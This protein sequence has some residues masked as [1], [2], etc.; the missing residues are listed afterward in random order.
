MTLS[1]DEKVKHYIELWKQTVSVQQHFNDIEW[2]IRGLALT[3]ATF[4]IG[5][6]AV[7]TKEGQ[8]PVA[9]LVL[10]IGL[11]L[12]YAFYFVDRYWYHP[13][14][15]ASV[16]QG[17]KIED[18]LVSHGLLNADLAK[19]IS[20]GSPIDRPRLIK[21]LSLPSNRGKKM[22]SVDKL[23]WFYR[24]GSIALFTSAVTL[25]LSLWLIPSKPSGPTIVRIE[26]TDL[27]EVSSSLTLE[28]SPLLTGAST[29]ATA[30]TGP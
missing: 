23:V 9:V 10:L 25:G 4:S 20:V 27:G 28:P 18:Q 2:R 7:A 1:D 21:A 14:L 22:H 19:Q 13:L 3:A 8:S 30:S 6:A 12:W 5:A 29:P 15:K 17:H 11:L 26:R 16:D 24:V